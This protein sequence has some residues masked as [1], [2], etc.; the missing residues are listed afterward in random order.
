MA[1][2]H[3]HVCVTKQRSEAAA[4]ARVAVRL[5][6][7]K[8]AALLELI[9]ASPQARGATGAACSCARPVYHPPIPEAV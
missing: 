7:R 2:P 5:G 9:I 6:L 1:Q 4:A 8:R 3:D